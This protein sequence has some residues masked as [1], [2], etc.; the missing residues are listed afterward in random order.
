MP[1]E[2]SEANLVCGI[3]GMMLHKEY[4]AAGERKAVALVERL[5]LAYADLAKDPAFKAIPSA[6][7][8]ALA[9]NAAPPCHY[10]LYV[11]EDYKAGQEAPLLL[12][13]HGGG[14]NFLGGFYLSVKDLKN[15]QTILVCPSFRNGE[16]WTEEGAA[17]A[18]Q[19][20]E[21][22]C[23]RYSVNKKA[24]AIAGVSNG[25]TGAW[26]I[27]QRNKEKFAAV[28]SISG[29]FEGGKALV[30]S[31]G[32]P[33]L[34]AHGAL[35]TVIPV[36]LSRN[37]FA[38]LKERKGTLYKEFPDAGHLVSMEKP[39]LGLSACLDWF[40]KLDGIPAP[41]GGDPARKGPAPQAPPPLRSPDKP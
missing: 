29:A 37:A 2:F 7:A 16:W 38:A 25:A 1:P 19:V 10:Y 6:L 14:G 40:Q 18:L 13:L 33:V 34:I 27:A 32:P 23:K 22:V 30:A 36:A 41:A 21:D 17:F 4:G 24:I 28:I 26:Q 39:E 15:R 20:L 3:L 9:G 8:P 11:P 35:D 12:F 5:K 31:P